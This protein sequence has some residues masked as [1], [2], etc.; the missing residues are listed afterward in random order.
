FFIF[1]I[2]LFSLFIPTNKIKSLSSLFFIIETK[3]YCLTRYHSNSYYYNM[4][5]N[6]IHKWYDT[7]ITASSR[8]LLLSFQNDY[9]KASSNSLWTVL[10]Q[11]TALFYPENILLL[12]I[13]VF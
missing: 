12:L 2:P 9:S 6:L 3:D 10:H 8:S 4:H 13:L 7:F 11:P 5:S 1:L